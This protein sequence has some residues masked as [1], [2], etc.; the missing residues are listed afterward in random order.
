MQ[1]LRAVGTLLIEYLFD[2]INLN[3]VHVGRNTNCDESLSHVERPGKGES[4]MKSRRN[5]YLHLINIKLDSTVRVRFSCQ[6]G[7]TAEVKSRHL[8]QF[9]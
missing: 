5:I 4:V 3:V 2:Y 6:R 1:N 8:Y 7:S 9:L